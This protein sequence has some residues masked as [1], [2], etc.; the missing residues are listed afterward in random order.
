MQGSRD[1]WIV[2]AGPAAEVAAAFEDH[3]II[4]VGYPELGDLTGLEWPD[5][6]AR[7]AAALPEISG[8]VYQVAAM[9]RRFAI[10]ISEGDCVATAVSG[11]G[12]LLFGIVIGPYE[13]RDAPGLGDYPHIRRVSWVGRLRRGDLP[14][15]V[16][17]G[18]RSPQTVF[19]PAAQDH[20]RKLDVWAKG[21]TQG[22]A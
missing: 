16:I 1:V 9:M 20:W 11:T 13:Y 10:N 17:Q 22:K 6:V 15:E 19:Q 7:A 4:A 18:L 14:P 12:D 5:L 21:E 2:R 8:K 3:S